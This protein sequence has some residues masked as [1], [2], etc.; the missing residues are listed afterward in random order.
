[1]QSAT[2]EWI[3]AVGA[4]NITITHGDPPRAGSPDIEVEVDSRRISTTTSFGMVTQDEREELV[5]NDAPLD[6]RSISRSGRTFMN[7]EE[8]TTAST[9]SSDIMR[10]VPQQRSESNE[11][12]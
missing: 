11:M 4:K 12:R 2:K 7:H 3:R 6:L 5:P 8:S 1:M 10:L 9:Q